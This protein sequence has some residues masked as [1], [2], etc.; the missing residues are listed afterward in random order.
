MKKKKDSKKKN[1]FYNHENE[2]AISRFRI[3]KI[4]GI[5]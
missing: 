4:V 5:W 1:L 3:N 2:K